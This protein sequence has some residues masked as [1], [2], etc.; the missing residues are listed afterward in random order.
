MACFA[1]KV[2]HGSGSPPA[3]S[4]ATVGHATRPVRGT[5]AKPNRGFRGLFVTRGGRK[6]QPEE[7]VESV[8][9]LSKGDLFGVDMKE[10]LAM[11]ANAPK[12]TTAVGKAQI[13]PE[14]V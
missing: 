2:G 14:E 9:R 10:L 13:S 11:Y 1:A 3:G 5:L 7:L 12:A 8:E 4:S 6:I